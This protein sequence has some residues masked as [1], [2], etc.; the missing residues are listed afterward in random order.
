MTENP[1]P[2]T[3][4]AEDR[5]PRWTPI[6]LGG[7]LP[8]ATGAYSR[9]ARAAGLVFVSGQVPRDFR[10]GE[11]AGDDLETQTRAVL[12]NLRAVLASAGAGLQDVVAVTVYLQ[13]VGDWDGFNAVYREVMPAPYPSRTV[14]G[15]DLRGIRVE[16]SAIAVSP[17][18]PGT[19]G[20]A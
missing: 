16:L 7:D 17:P 4:P 19:R 6:E 1:S 8:K 20:P 11:L 15:A 9:A 10:T 14:V 18:G 12:E 5:A 13:D 3:P 2:E